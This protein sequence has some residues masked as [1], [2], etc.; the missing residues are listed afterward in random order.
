M[1]DG[2]QQSDVPF[3]REVPREYSTRAFTS[4]QKLTGR[5]AKEQYGDFLQSK[6]NKAMIACL[7]WGSDYFAIM[8]RR[9]QEESPEYFEERGTDMNEFKRQFLHEVCYEQI[10]TYDAAYRNKTVDIVSKGVLNDQIRRLTNKG[11]KF[12]PYL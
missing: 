6:H 4:T 9:V 7:N 11:D 10:A 3:T 1:S 5:S 2:E 12:H 8:K